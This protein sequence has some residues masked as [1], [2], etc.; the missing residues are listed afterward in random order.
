MRISL[1]TLGRFFALG[2]CCGCK[3]PISIKKRE[4]DLLEKK[5]D[6]GVSAVSKLQSSVPRG[7][8]P[9][10]EGGLLPFLKKNKFVF[11]VVLVVAAVALSMGLMKVMGSSSSKLKSPKKEGAS[12]GTVAVN[13]VELKADRFQDVMLTVG[14][15]KGGSEIPLR[16]ETD[17]NVSKFD[18]RQGDKIRKGDVI[19]QLDQRDAFLKLK[20][21]RLELEQMEKLYAIGGVSLNKLEEAK[22]Q[23]DL[24]ALEYQKTI[25]H[26]PRDG[27]LGD[28]DAEVG[29]FVTPAKRIATLVNIET[30][31][32]EMG[33]VEKQID[34][35]FPGQKVLVTVDT[36]Q[37]VEF[38]GKIENISPIITPGSRTL[39]IEA[40]LDNEGGLLLPG[41]F[42]RTRITVFEQDNALSVPNDAV[43]KTA[44]GSRV[45]VVTK[46]NKAE[47]RDVEVSYVSSQFSLLAK[48]VEPGELVITQRPQ[49]LKAGASVKIIEKS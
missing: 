13:V 35:I 6:Q 30:V 32:V 42:A 11:V 7:I 26:A 45:F 8:P 10:W 33:V 34:R 41:M 39:S 15:I 43:E 9:R 38:T 22:V 12:G 2:L 16:F 47:S 18:F 21:A 19:A 28:K 49:D 40:R 37:N 17:G 36:Y 20:K 5:S 14:T 31:V 27:I 44:T 4:G 29:E 46:D 24:A 23:A 25:I 48:G 3:R 1:L